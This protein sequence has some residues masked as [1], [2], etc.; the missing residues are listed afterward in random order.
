MEGITGFDLAEKLLH[1]TKSFGL[2]IVQQAVSEIS[3]D[4]ISFVR[5]D[6]GDLFIVLALYWRQEDRYESWASPA[7]RNIWGQVFPI[8]PPAT[9]SFSGQDCR[10]CRGGDTAVEEALYLARLTRKVF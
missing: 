10:R 9:V 8:V 1:H 3:S 2:P 6:N 5:L 7:K 4:R